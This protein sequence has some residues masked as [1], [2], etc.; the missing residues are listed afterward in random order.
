MSRPTYPVYARPCGWNA[1]LPPAVPRPALAG[2]VTADYAI[3]GAGFTGLAAARRLH[4]LDPQARIVVVDAAPIGEGSAGRNSGFTGQDVLPRNATLEGAAAA[5]AQSTLIA[6]A[7]QSL[8]QLIADHRID[9]Q[10]KQVGSIRGAATAAGEASLHKVAEVARANDIAH[11]LLDRTAIRDR[12]GSDYYRFGVHIND[13]YLLQPAALIRGLA[14][15]L[16]A[17]ITLHENSPIHRLHR[18]G[19]G[20]RL[21][22]DQGTIRARQVV[23]A[24]NGFIRRFGYL[25]LRMTTIYTYAAITAAVPAADLDQLG[26]AVDWGLLPC[27]RLGTTLRRVGADRL[28]VRSL[29]AHEAELPPARVDQELRQRF[30]RRWP[31]LHH[32]PFEY[33][34]GGTTALTMNG[35]PWWGQLDQGLYA[36]GGCNGSGIAKGTMLGRRLAE[37]MRG[38]GDT[39]AVP[40]I[41]GTANLIAPEPFRSIGFNVISAIERHKAGLES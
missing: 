18:D 35:A 37:L 30:E 9:C 17:A 39:T 14:D 32:V 24:N 41:M 7:F 2:D 15:A 25:K 27:H 4:E 20:W 29:Y 3:I 8:L 21:T 34:W 1:M 40:R 28:M 23:L 6:E 31:G 5:R 16:P 36:S 26:Q 22:G 13:T 33:V 19:G 38:H 11:Q 12:I 10:L